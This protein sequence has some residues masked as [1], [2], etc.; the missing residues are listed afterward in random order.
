VATGEAEPK[1]NSFWRLSIEKRREDL[2]LVV[3]RE[4]EAA[5][6]RA[7]SCKEVRMRTREVLVLNRAGM[8]R[9]N[10]TSDMLERSEKPRLAHQRSSSRT[11]C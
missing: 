5:S 7:W 4:G 11:E 3:V 10:C 6:K 1:E 9:I 2:R 8:I